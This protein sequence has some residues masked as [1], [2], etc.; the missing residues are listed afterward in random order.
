MST[1]SLFELSEA[2]AEG[3][4]GPALRSVDLRIRDRAVTALVGPMGSGKSTM[5]RRMSGRPLSDGWSTTGRWSFRGRPLP[6]RYPLRGVAW[7]PQIRNAP[8]GEFRERH[9]QQAA[10]ARVEA[11]LFGGSVVLLD[12]PTRG[13]AADDRESLTE[14]VRAKAEDGAAVVVSHDLGFIREVADDVCLLCDGELVAH[15]SADEFFTGKGSDLVR[16]FVE[17]GTCAQAPE[18]PALPRH[19]HWHGPQRLAGMGQ[20]GLMSELDDDLFA[21]AHAGITDLVSLTE[22]PLP[23]ARLRPFGLVG[24]HF[25]INDMGVPGV[26]ETLSLCHDLLR[27]MQR[28]RV[29][30]VH[31]RAGL[32]R[33]GL[34]LASLAV[35]EGMDADEAI[36]QVRQVAPGS[37]QT[38]EQADFVH[39]LEARR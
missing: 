30:A 36:D 29:V 27:A 23:T 6:T 9:E 20:P 22:V 13:L 21:I 3:P 35:C 19:F 31:C 34:I 18:P 28:D 11:A 2:Q 32:G 33:T 4:R 12:E 25:P 26:G 5:L 17:R 15:V 1:A 14:R 16:Q 8:A 24:R 39:Q 37:I 38:Q 7:A 10:W